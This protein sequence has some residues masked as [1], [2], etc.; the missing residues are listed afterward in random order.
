MAV[1]PS[2][3]RLLHFSTGRFLRGG[4]RQALLLH[5]GLL[6]RGIAST[7]VCN[8]SGELC[9]EA[10]KNTL[11]VAWNGEWDITALIRFITICRARK[12]SLIHCHDGHSLSHAAV[13]GALFRIPV[14]Y[15]RRV[16]FPIG[17]SFFSTW[18]YRS[19][20]AVIAVSEAVA[21]QCRDVV[22]ASRVHVVGDGVDCSAPLLGRD[23]ARKRLGIPRGCFA[24]GTV[25]HFTREKDFALVYYLGGR[26]EAENPD[27]KLVCIG[28]YDEKRK[29]RL[30]LPESLVCT[31]PL[32]NA[33]QYYGA[34]DAYVS[35]SSYEGLGS[36]L[37]DAV[38]RDIPA[39]AVDAEGTRDIFPQGHP[40]VMR[41]DYEAFAAA[42]AAMVRGYE[43]ATAE[44][45]RCG[46]RARDIFSVDAMVE[47][48]LTIYAALA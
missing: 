16:I 10:M 8:K 48:T 22:P 28:P 2:K 7:M 42:V 43:A 6:G 31:G 27:V 1:P 38:V 36:A 9:A 12:P 3:T 19:C 37:L 13:A 11:A 46:A 29:K 45:K 5:K 44:A 41:G 47:K 17:A 26:L 18:K 14:V 23:E 25:A 39:V 34:F 20:A 4:E 21:Q 15:T 40:L 24:V 33:V 32:D 35:T 30:S